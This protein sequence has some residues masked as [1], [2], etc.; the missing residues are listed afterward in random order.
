M[1]KPNIECTQCRKVFYKKP[2]VI[3][4]GDKHFC[5][6]ECY[7]FF[8]KR[9]DRFCLTCKKPL[10]KY[11]QK[12]FCSN[13]C[14]A[15][16]RVGKKQKP[17][18]SEKRLE[19]LGLDRK[20]ELDKNTGKRK[21]LKKC[22]ICGKRVWSGSENC[23][24]CDGHIKRI[25]YSELTLEKAISISTGN[26]TK[27]WQQNIRRH[28]RNMMKYE[29]KKPKKCHI[30]GYDTYVET[31]HIKPVSKFEKTVK[32]KEVNSEENLVYL[33]PN[34]HKEFDLGL[35]SLKESKM[36][37]D[38]RTIIPVISGGFDP[39]HIGHLRMIKAAAKLSTNTKTV[40]VGVNSDEWLVR[41]KGAYFM[42]FD[43]RKELIEGYKEV[44]QAMSFDDSDD[45]AFDFLKQVR[46][47]YPVEIF[48]I[49]FCNGGDRVEGHVPEESVAE[50][51]D[52]EFAYGIGG[53]KVES[54]SELVGK[55]LE[56]TEE[57]DT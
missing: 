26:T 51:L 44:Y 50:E 33:C 15:L 48:R 13:K 2:S 20:S 11:W 16:S 36:N 45:S 30:C 35:I 41:K 7:N 47:K 39:L 22:K 54:S 3:A 53:G 23:L 52:I 25:S 14:H 43:H 56:Y 4:L 10:T 49:I 37:N 1:G 32:I 57:N 55:Y 31:C 19:T 17:E 40:I 12:Y 8:R 42:T 5:S 24:K 46:A 29:Y 34:H 6:L 28:A 38:D 21:P 9:E 18:S 27:F